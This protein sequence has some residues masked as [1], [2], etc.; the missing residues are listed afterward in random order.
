MLNRSREPRSFSG[1]AFERLDLSGNPIGRF[2]GALWNSKNFTYIAA[3]YCASIKIFGDEN[4]PY[5]D[6]PDCHGGYVGIIQP[7]TDE[8]DR[9]LLFW[10]QREGSTQ[11]RVLWLDQEVARCDISAE[12]CDFYVP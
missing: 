9:H 12:T 6:P 1:F 3:K 4:P 2:N 8:A 11:F 10:N 7:R 5:L